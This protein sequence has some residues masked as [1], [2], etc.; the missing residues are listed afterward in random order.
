M[1]LVQIEARDLPEA[2]YLCIRECM[3]H[4]YIYTIDRGSH[5]GQQRKE[6]DSITLRVKYPGSRP[7]VPVVPE[8]VPP[9]STQDYVE[10]YLP[11]LMCGQKEGNEQYTYGQDIEAQLPFLIKMYKEDGFGTNQGCMS[12]GSAQSILMSDPPFLCLLPV[13][14]PLGWFPFELG[15]HP[16]SEGVRGQ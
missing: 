10:Q 15:C 1:E 16:N 2:W 3:H 9:P 8:G 4:G 6:F 13:M 7:L 5:Q 11:Y 14:G 12:I